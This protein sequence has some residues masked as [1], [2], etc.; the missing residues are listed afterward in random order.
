MSAQDAISALKRLGLSNYEARV[1]VALQQLGTATTAE[2]SDVSEV[3]RSQVYGAAD[4][5]V[6]RGLT[7]V[8]ESAPKQYRPV[9]LDAAREQLRSRVDRAEERAFDNLDALRTDEPDHRGGQDVST[10]RG[11]QPIDERIAELV[12]DAA[13]SVVLVAP[14]TG[15]ISTAIAGA[16]RERAADGISVTVLTAES[17]L[18]ERFDGDAVEVVLMNEDNPGDFAGRALLVDGSTVLLAAATER[19]EPVE[20]EA[21]WT[22]DTSIGRILAQFMRSGMEFGTERGDGPNR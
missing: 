6:E 21:M 1:F 11:R 15:S 19:G 2:I 13:D 16:L 3:P 4:E 10:L 12:V 18:V 20:E 14:A 8:I 17:S 7:E 9:S 22:A 5:L